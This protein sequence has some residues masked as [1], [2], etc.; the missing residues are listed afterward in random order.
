LDV[1]NC[2][3]SREPAEDA[4]RT[5]PTALRRL[6]NGVRIALAGASAEVRVYSRREAELAALNEYEKVRE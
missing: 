4:R 5:A 6:L 3:G 2:E 1:L